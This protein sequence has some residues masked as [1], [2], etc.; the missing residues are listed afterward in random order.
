M[1]ILFFILFS[2][3]SAFAQDWQNRDAVHGQADVAS[4]FFLAGWLIPNF[5]TETLDN[6]NLFGGVGYRGK[7]WWLETMAQHQWNSKQ[8]QW[9]LDFRYDRQIGRWHV[10]AE[11]A[12]FLTKRAFYEFAVVERQTWKGFLF[13]AETENVHQPGPDTVAVGP[14][15]GRK[16]GRVA[17]FEVSAI[18]AVRLS[19]NGGH[20]EP[21]LYV[22]FNQRVKRR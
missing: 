22:V 5:W 11:G 12:P 10:Y 17:G 4:K 20:T 6:V 7:D 8:N 18:A 14:R 2:L 9:A 13:G 3:A 15:A 16:L 21:R 1:R 19:P